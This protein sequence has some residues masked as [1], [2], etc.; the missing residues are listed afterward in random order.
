MICGAFSA[1]GKADLV[2]MEG[3]QNAQKYAE[4]IER[5]LLPLVMLVIHGR[6]FIIQQD[7]AAIHTSMVTNA[8]F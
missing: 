7:N 5:S 4:V 3:H 2:V 1:I 6:D 8:W